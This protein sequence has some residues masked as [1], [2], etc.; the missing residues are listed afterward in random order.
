LGAVKS[1]GLQFFFTD[2]HAR[3]RTSTAYANEADLQKLDWEAIY[4]SNWKSDESDLRRKEK[5]QSE[6]FVKGHVPFSCMEH[7]G[8]FNKTAEQKVLYLFNSHSIN[9]PI[10]ISPQRLY[11]DHL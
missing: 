5:K 10:K 1:A 7:I 11:Y 6:F 9:T 3:S 4:A 2:G 8:V